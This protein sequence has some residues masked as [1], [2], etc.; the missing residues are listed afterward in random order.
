MT[1]QKKVENII[2]K[3]VEQ[4]KLFSCWDITKLARQEIEESIFHKDIRNITYSYMNNLGSS[5][6]YTRSTHT[7]VINENNVT[8]E[9]FHP[10][11]INVNKYN[12]NHIK[13]NILNKKNSHIFKYINRQKSHIANSLQWKNSKDLNSSNKLGTS[14]LYKKIVN[15]YHDLGKSKK[16]FIIK[17]KY[18]GD[19]ISVPSVAINT[20]VDKSEN[21]VYV[22]KTVTKGLLLITNKPW[23]IHKVLNK[24]KIDK[25]RNVKLNKNILEEC[26]VNT[27]KSEIS[28]RVKN[29]YII[30]EN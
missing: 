11:W 15:T 8:S 17:R 12:P 19:R 4:E 9:I 18:H 13:S 3:L 7:F 27:N 21:F 14:S 2:D 28:F 29:D 10:Y 26:G 24:L 1:N 30:V 6:D 25:Y 22:H 23:H 20:I 5:Y 16:S